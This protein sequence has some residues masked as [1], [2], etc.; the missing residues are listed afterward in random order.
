MYSP[1]L[2]KYRDSYV[3]YKPTVHTFGTLNW[4]TLFW[5]R[6]TH[7]TFP[8]PGV[9]PILRIFSVMD[10]N[11]LN[12]HVSRALTNKGGGNGLTS[13]LF[14]LPCCKSKIAR[15]VWNL[16]ENEK[17]IYSKPATCVRRIFQL[18]LL[19]KSASATSIENCSWKFL[20][21]KTEYL[22]K[23]FSSKKIKGHLKLRR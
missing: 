10:F 23:I 17:K 15:N 21:R 4:H 13:P 20:D 16:I 22:H 8:P 11:N 2:Y 3:L 7:M 18:Y 9:N 12:T 6:H 14:V 1:R 19:H 5:Y